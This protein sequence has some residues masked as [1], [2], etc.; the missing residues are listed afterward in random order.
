MVR[1]VSP[2]YPKLEVEY[3][4]PV[5]QM[6]T[7]LNGQIQTIESPGE[8]INFQ[9]HVFET[10]DPDKINFIRNH[11]AFTGVNAVQSIFE[12]PTPTAEDLQLQQLLQQYGSAQI[13]SVLQNQMAAAAQQGVVYQQQPTTNDPLSHTVQQQQRAS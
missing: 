4:K 5:Q 9:N 8:Y 3:R 12:T 2:K 13:L 1:F 7:G 6:A 11:P 10:N